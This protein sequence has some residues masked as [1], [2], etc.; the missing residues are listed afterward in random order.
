MPNLKCKVKCYAEGS[1]YSHFCKRNAWK[2]GFCKQHHPETIKERDAAKEIKYQKKL[3]ASAPYQLNKAVKKL[4]AIA[5][6]IDQ[7]EEDGMP[8][9]YLL[10]ESKS[11]LKSHTHFLLIK[12]VAKCNLND[13]EALLLLNLMWRTI[14]GE[15]TIDLGYSINSILDKSSCGFFL[16]N[17]FK[18]V[19]EEAVIRD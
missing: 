19:V 3:E 15:D 11:L 16:P 5:A 17:W 13:F 2:D 18:L 10:E 8:T 4:V 14:I 7:K 9:I 1:F 12:K 6:L